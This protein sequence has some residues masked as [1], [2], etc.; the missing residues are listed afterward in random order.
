MANVD[1]AFG[2]RPLRRNGASYVTGGGNVYSVPSGYA[3]PI[4]PGD[5]VVKISDGAINGVPSVNVAG[6]TGV[7]TGVCLGIANSPDPSL[8]ASADGSVTF[9]TPLNTIAS[10][11]FDQY[12]LVEDDPQ[13]TYAIQNDETL[14]DT[15]IGANADMV[16]GTPTEG[17]SRFELDTST[18]STT[19]TLQLKILR[20]VQLP[21]NEMGEFAVVEVLINASTQ[22]NNTAG[23]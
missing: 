23:I 5:P 12:I 11:S 18:I 17:K 21:D 9:D 6:A 16:A 2:L 13:V 15:L 8:E 10:A 3:T 22:A 1:N 14:T 19:S 4:A 7:V 20:L